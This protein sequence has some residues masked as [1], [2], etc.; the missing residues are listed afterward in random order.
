VAPRNPSYSSPP[1]R[2]HRRRLSCAWLLILL[3]PLAT[4]PAVQAEPQA[5]VRRALLIGINHYLA[6]PSLQGSVNDVQTMR[7]ILVTR[8]G[9]EPGNVRVLTDEQATRDAIMQAFEKLIRETA[10][11]DIV[12][13]HFSGHGSQVEDVSGHKEDRTSET[14]VPQDGRTAEVADIVDLELAVVL[15][16]LRA[17]AG[18]V[19]LDSCHSGTATRA[20]DIRVRSI[21]PDTRTEL[22]QRGSTRAVVPAPSSRFVVFDATAAD[23]EALDGPIDGQFHGFFSYALARSMSNASADTALLQIFNGALQELNRLQVHFGRISMPEPQLEAPPALLAQPLFTSLGQADPLAAAGREPRLPWAAV[24]PITPAE[25]KLVKAVLLGASPG[26]RWAIY[27]PGETEFAPGKAAAQATV[28]RVEQ[29]DAFVR[30]VD[31]VGPLQPGARAVL[32]TP[33][34]AANRV[35]V[36]LVHMTPAERARVE[37]ILS[38]DIVKLVG[39][40]E[41]AQ[42]LIGLQGSSMQLM[43]A[44]GLKV[45]A[46]YAP[47]QP[48]A[49]DEL[50]RLLERSAK[51]AAIL[52]LDNAA[53]LIKISA[54][55]AGRSSSIQRGIALVADTQA[56]AFRIRRSGEPRTAANSLRLE[57]QVNSDAYLTIVDVDSAGGINQLFPNSYQSKSFYPQGLVHA[58]ERVLLPDSL[59]SGNLAGFH[60]DYGPPHGT[61]TLRVFAT[62]DLATAELIRKRISEL[63][64][65]SDPSQRT[66]SLDQASATIADLGGELAARAAGTM[67]PQQPGAPGAGGSRRSDWAAA[68]V[69]IDVAD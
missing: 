23:E 66:R 27:P 43:T 11:E 36:R 9:F 6:V 60:W 59:D 15:A 58:G 17:R 7:E 18:I 31:G 3:L 29:A 26:S 33:A 39:P 25:A 62:S 69:M 54:R 28:E 5:G 14:I 16:R 1:G 50:S 34:P 67:A 21:P 57:V 30:V 44:D 52:S 65:A 56:A 35:P 20:I 40:S 41:P 13:I 38:R 42:Y 53:S 47:D 63:G 10:P 4:A 61:D 12:Y 51:A 68:S 64:R 2:G 46:E 19:V 37:S 55:V 24:L 45:V 8:Y 49:A 32:L 48:A 22:Y